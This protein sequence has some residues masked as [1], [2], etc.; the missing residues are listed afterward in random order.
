MLRGVLNNY[1]NLEE[2]LAEV[3]REYDL[4]HEDT[5][6]RTQAFTEMLTHYAFTAPAVFEAENH[7]RSVYIYMFMTSAYRKLRKQVYAMKWA[8][9]LSL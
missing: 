5:D 4:V 1:R 2:L 3:Y 6:K 8:N 9:N 7:A